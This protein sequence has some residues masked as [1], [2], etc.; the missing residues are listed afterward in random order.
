MTPE[1]LAARASPALLTALPWLWELHRRP[2]QAP[3]PGAWATWLV[4][5]GRGSG[6]TRA[7]AEWVRSLVEGE[8]PLAP[9]RR[10]RIALL[11]QTAEQARD[12]MVLGES[13]LMACAPPGWRPTL[14]HT[15][16]RLVWPNGAEAR[17]FSAAD[18]DSLRGPQFDAAWCDEAAKW[19]EGEAAWAN[20]SLALRLGDDPRACVTTTPRPVPLVRAL[21]ADPATA[22]TRMRTEENAAHLA[23]GFVERMRARWGGTD[24]ARQELDGELLSEAEGAL[25]QRGWIDRHR[26]AAAPSLARVVVAVDPP[27][28]GRDACGIVV[29]G[30][31][32]EGRAWVLE[33][34][35]V[36][37]LSPA[38]WA[39]AAVAAYRRHAADRLVAEVNQGGDMVAAVIRAAD[40]GVAYG[41]VRATRGKALRA[42]PVAALY[43]QGRVHHVRGADL[44]VLEDQLTG[45]VPARPFPGSPDRLDA[46]VWALTDLMLGKAA[47]VPRISAL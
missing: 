17:L 19:R 30:C 5:G 9:G 34:A 27:A 11:A 21:L 31:C 26:R 41:A 28:G 6:K 32:A 38:G 45:Y 13:G 3:P 40:P 39:A 8:T 14:T 35:S 47:R 7:G 16:R 20:L 15:R 12:V 4:M 46:L 25:W 23:P 10:R 33:D 22:V 36:Q 44:A 29:A 2:A 43:E 37:G 24:R 1:T 18:P 42:E